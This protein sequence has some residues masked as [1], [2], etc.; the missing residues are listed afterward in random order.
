MMGEERQLG[1]AASMNDYLSKPPLQ[2]PDLIR[3]FGR[4]LRAQPESP[5]GA[6][7]VAG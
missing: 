1:E 5:V 7:D 2:M 6:V 4:F 3:V